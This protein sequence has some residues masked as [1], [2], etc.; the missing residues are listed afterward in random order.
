MKELRNVVVTIVVIVIVV[1]L[2]TGHGADVMAFI[3]ALLAEVTKYLS[4]V[5][6]AVAL[7]TLLLGGLLYVSPWNR[8]LAVRLM[9]GAVVVLAIAV[10]GPLV[11]T[12]LD[13]QF[14]TYGTRLF[15][16]K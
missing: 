1:N 10:L 9:T 14:T 4:R 12:W 13:A 7:P 15:G 11:L 8:D 16:G 2:L 3:I 5:L 6:V